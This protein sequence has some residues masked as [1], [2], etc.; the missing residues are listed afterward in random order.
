VLCAP[1]A[2][3]SP[4]AALQKWLDFRLVLAYRSVGESLVSSFCFLLTFMNRSVQDTRLRFSTQLSILPKL[5][6]QMYDGTRK[7]VLPHFPCSA[8][9]LIH[10]E[11]N[12]ESL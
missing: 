2:A 4:A 1:L 7:L 11:T 8:I 3:L 5:F 10:Q 6:L 12:A 9:V